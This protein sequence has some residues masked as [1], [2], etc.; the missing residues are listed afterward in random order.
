M[1]VELSN[2]ILNVVLTFLQ[3]NTTIVKTFPSDIFRTNI[4]THLVITFQNTTG[5]REATQ[6]NSVVV[7]FFINNV[8]SES[9]ILQMDFPTAVL[10]AEIGNGYFGVLQ[11]IGLYLPS[12]IESDLDPEKADFLSQCLCYPKDIYSTD[13]SLCGNISVQQNR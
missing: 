6:E 4:W 1:T 12:L 3:V 5:P 13:P 11:D 7:N 9:T 2:N 10:S 8:K